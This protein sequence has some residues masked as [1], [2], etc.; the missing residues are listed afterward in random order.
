M[1]I[2]E[3]KIRIKIE[4]K[5]NKIKKENLLK[6]FCIIAAFKKVEKGNEYEK[7]WIHLKY[8]KEMMISEYINIFKIVRTPFLYEFI[9]YFKNMD[10]KFNRQN[11]ETKIGLNDY[12]EEIEEISQEILIVMVFN[13]KSDIKEIEEEA[14]KI[15][16]IIEVIDID[17]LI[18]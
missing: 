9:S 12:L 5:I 16:K 17:S 2:K 13:I 14:E 15:M 10:E 4:E 1:E 3:N 18:R 7:A 6:I 8:K 11:T